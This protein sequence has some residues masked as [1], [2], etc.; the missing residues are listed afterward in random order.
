M[1][2]M[3]QTYEK[4][5]LDP[6]VALRPSSIMKEENEANPVQEDAV[7]GDITERGPNYRNVRESKSPLVV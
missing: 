2:N 4:R 1:I 6:E 7:F 3:S 5:E